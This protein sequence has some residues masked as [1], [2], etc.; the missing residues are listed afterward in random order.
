MLDRLPNA[1]VSMHKSR[2]HYFESYYILYDSTGQVHVMSIQRSGL[3]L[4]G[5]TVFDRTLKRI[6]PSSTMSR[7]IG[8]YG[9]SA[10]NKANF[11]LVNILDLRT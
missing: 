7:G 8:V 11:F 10:Q 2:A 9:V 4:G 3:Q 6:I 5:A 1:T